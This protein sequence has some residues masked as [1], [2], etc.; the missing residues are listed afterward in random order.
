MENLTFEYNKVWFGGILVITTKLDIQ[1]S[2]MTRN[3]VK[4]YMIHVQFGFLFMRFCYK[5]MGASKLSFPNS[6]LIALLILDL[7]GPQPFTKSYGGCTTF[8]VFFTHEQISHWRVDVTPF[9]WK[10]VLCHFGRGIFGDYYFIILFGN[11]AII[12]PYFRLDYVVLLYKF[13]SKVM[14]S[15]N[16]R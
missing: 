6:H 1:E 13:H 11:L 8:G 4:S 2:K 14:K 10:I 3:S 7:L 12:I 5:L 15:F 9:Y 16:W